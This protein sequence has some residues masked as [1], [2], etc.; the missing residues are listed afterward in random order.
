MFKKETNIIPLEKG[1]AFGI[2]YTVD[3]KESITV[4]ERV[5]FPAPGLTNSYTKVRKKYSEIEKEVN[6]ELD[7][8]SSYKLSEEW[9]LVP[10]EWVIIILHNHRVILE[11]AFNVVPNS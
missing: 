3:S 11:K 4:I 2:E 9:E 10:G 6:R 5:T 8:Q 7:I 1:I